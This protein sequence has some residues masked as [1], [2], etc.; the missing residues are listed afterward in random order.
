MLEDRAQQLTVVQLRIE[1][2]ADLGGGGFEPLALHQAFRRRPRRLGG[3]IF[4]HRLA[5][6]HPPPLVEIDQ[7][8]PIDYPARPADLVHQRRDQVLS[9]IH[10]VVEIRIGL[11]PFE[12]REFGVV[13]I[14]QPLVAEVAVDFVDLLEAADDQ[15]LQIKLG[16]DARVK[17][18]VERFVVRDERA[19]RRAGR[20]RRKH[21]RLDFDVA[22]V[23]EIMADFADDLRAPLEDLARSQFAEGLSLPRR[24]R[25][26]QRSA[27]G[28]AAPCRSRHDICR[29]SAAAPWPGMKPGHVDRKLAGLRDEQK[30]FNAEPIAEVQLLI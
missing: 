5:H 6:R 18:D 8:V 9:Q 12:H 30:T 20:Q 3:P 16:R 13:L 15:P 7:A 26:G 19:R 23:V 4:Q 24:W 14:R 2:Q 11:I 21:R 27:G 17:V 10:E 1:V 22:S 25:S 28:S 29:A